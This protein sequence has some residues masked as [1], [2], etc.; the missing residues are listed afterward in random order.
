VRVGPATATL[1]AKPAAATARTYGDTAITGFTGAGFVALRQAG[2]ARI[3]VPVR[4]DRAGAYEVDVRYA[5]G[6]GPVNTDSKAAVR[7][8]LVDGREAGVV[9]MPQR[10][11]GAWSEWG[12]STGLRVRL[13]PGAHTLSLAYTPLDANMDRRV[14]TA[15]V[16]HVRLARVAP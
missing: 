3:D 15:L 10:G 2:P 5:N 16:D 4:V 9:V 14:N 1:I 7:T 11:T 6:N 12:Y 13:A 8:L